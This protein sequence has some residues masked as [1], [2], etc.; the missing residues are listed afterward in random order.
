MRDATGGTGPHA[1][2]PIARAGAPPGDAAGALILL[3]GRGGDAEEMLGLA[4]LVAPPSLACLA[5][6]AAGSTW[7][8]WRFTEPAAR[9]EPHLSSALSVL[10]DLM[11]RLAR[12]GLPAERIALLGFSQGACLALEFALRR[13]QRLGAVLGLSGGLIGDS[14]APPPAGARPFQGMPVLL[15]CSEHDPHIPIGRVRETEAVMSGLGAEVATRIYPGGGHGIN[16]DEVAVA[17]RILAQL[18]EAMPPT[19]L[20]GTK[21]RNS[22]REEVGT[23]RGRG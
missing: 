12:D 17:R 20:T 16:D 22:R 13:A 2:Q 6:Q 4:G 5:P 11:E 3:H 23:G 18:P 7:Y 8:P 1:G 15:G 10:G 9:N 14:V 21:A 19:R